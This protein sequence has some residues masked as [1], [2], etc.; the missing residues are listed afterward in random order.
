[1]EGAL[2]PPPP[3]LTRSLQL[4]QLLLQIHT[5]RNQSHRHQLPLLIHMPTIGQWPIHMPIRSLLPIHMVKNNSSSSQWPIHMVKNNRLRLI[6]R[7]LVRSPLLLLLLLLPPPIR[8][9][10]TH[11]PIMV[12]HSVQMHYGQTS[13]HPNQHEIF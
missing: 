6:I 2:L 4:Q 9:E 5:I 11:P 7:T 10:S 8:V 3:M 12:N 1:M 13:M